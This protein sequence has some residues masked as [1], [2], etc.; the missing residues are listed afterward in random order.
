MQIDNFELRRTAIQMRVRRLMKSC[1][2]ETLLDK[3]RDTGVCGLME[4]TLCIYL[5]YAQMLRITAALQYRD[6]RATSAKP[7]T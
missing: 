5:K 1:P 3:W 7:I 4:T 6:R 2:P